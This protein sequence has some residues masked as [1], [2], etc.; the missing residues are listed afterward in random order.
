M[1]LRTGLT[2][3][4]VAIAQPMAPPR[5]LRIVPLPHRHLVHRAPA[6]CLGWYAGL[7]RW[8]G[9]GLAVGDDVAIGSDMAID[10]RWAWL[11]CGAL[12]R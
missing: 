6:L 12:R 11:S 7:W 9:S 1:A 5:A 10:G 8:A 2:F 3:A 4:I